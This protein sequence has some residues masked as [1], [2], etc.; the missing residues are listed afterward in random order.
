A[1]YRLAW[2]EQQGVPLTSV[3]A[4]FLYV[5]TGEVVRPGGLPDRAALERLLLGEAYGDEPH[6]QGVGADQ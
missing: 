5:R 1:V 2:A 3:T 4:A 6:G